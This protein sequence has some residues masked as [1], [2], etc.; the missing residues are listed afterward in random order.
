M[1]L[2]NLHQR[3]LPALGV[4]FLSL[5]TVSSRPLRIKGSADWSGTAVKRLVLSEVAPLSDAVPVLPV[6]RDRKPNSDFKLAHAKSRPL[7]AR[8]TERS[9]R[10]VLRSASHQLLRR[11]HTGRGPAGT[12]E[13]LNQRLL[14]S[15]KMVPAAASPTPLLQGT[16]I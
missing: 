1:I 15:Q 13:V 2:P 14:W 6:A 11:L 5:P 16:S 10:L 12:Q 3:I 4:V 8:V 7:P 9:E